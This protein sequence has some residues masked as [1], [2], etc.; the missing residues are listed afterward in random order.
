MC[1]SSADSPSCNPS[2]QLVS[3]PLFEHQQTWS[4]MYATNGNESQV[5]SF[6]AFKLLLVL[7]RTAQPI[8][9]L[10]ISIVILVFL[11]KRSYPTKEQIKQ[12]PTKKTLKLIAVRRLSL[13]YFRGFFCRP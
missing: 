5:P 3:A 11:P 13:F 4:M 9:P 12:R 7:C 6:G 10:D 8:F 1:T 2:S